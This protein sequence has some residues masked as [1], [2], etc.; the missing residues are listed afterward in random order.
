MEVRHVQVKITVA[1]DIRQRHRHAP[2]RRGQTGF[3]GHLDEPAGAVVA[4][5][6]RTI[7]KRVHEQVKIVVAVHVHERCGGRVLPVAGEAVRPRDIL[8]RPVAQV[9]V[10]PVP[11]VESAKIKVAPA[12]SVKVTGGH[13]RT[14]Q[15]VAVADGSL[16]VELV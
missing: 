1:V 3:P 8:K 12:V 14:A 2:R 4:E 5:Q 11:V 10:Q 9:S 16:I 6:P 15:K 13:P 7:A